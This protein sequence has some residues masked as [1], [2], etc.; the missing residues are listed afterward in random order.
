MVVYPVIFIFIK[1]GCP[2]C[3]NTMKG[4]KALEKDI[5]T[6]CPEAEIRVIAYG[7]DWKTR[8][9]N[10]NDH[11]DL[12]NVD[13]S[14]EGPPISFLHFAP[15]FGAVRSD[16]VKILESYK[17]NGAVYNPKQKFFEQ[18][19]DKHEFIRNWITRV[20][21]EI[22]EDIKNKNTNIDPEFEKK[23]LS[24]ALNRIKEKNNNKSVPNIPNIPN[25]NRKYFFQMVGLE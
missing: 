23:E 10:I 2:A 19:Q 18:Q 9:Y 4:Y 21:N 11:G 17:V 20:T 16:Q 14:K 12:K 22:R 1:D 15:M 5:K 8:I 24:A 3:T 6:I 7:N 13:I 25:N